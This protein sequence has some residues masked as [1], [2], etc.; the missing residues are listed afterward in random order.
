MQLGGR[1]GSTLK[2][3]P[4]GDK[5]GWWLSRYSKELASG[6]T[7]TEEEARREGLEAYAQQSWTAA[8]KAKDKAKARSKLKY[9]IDS[10]PYLVAHLLRCLRY[11]GMDLG[12]YMKEAEQ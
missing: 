9:W 4:A 3:K 1:F 5:W 10:R 8:V 11:P 12:R 2:I 7:R 6:V